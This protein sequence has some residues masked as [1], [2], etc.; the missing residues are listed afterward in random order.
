MKNREE[1]KAGS[2]TA[3]PAF[4]NGRPEPILFLHQLFAQMQRKKRLLCPLDTFQKKPDKRHKKIHNPPSNI[5]WRYIYVRSFR[6]A[7][8]FVFSYT[9]IFAPS[10]GC[11]Y[12]V[13]KYNNT[14]GCDA[15]SAVY[16]R[17]LCICNILHLI[18]RGD[19][20][21]KI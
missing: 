10:M 3:V 16:A 8:S 7:P 4:R 5:S 12:R 15:F 11:S 18:D 21:I 6:I 20:G 14:R 17:D 1:E 19:V 2:A 13:W 9:D